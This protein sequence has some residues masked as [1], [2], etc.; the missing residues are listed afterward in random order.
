M[1]SIKTVFFRAGGVLLPSL[2]QTAVDVLKRSG[3]VSVK[4]RTRDEVHT[5]AESLA[6]GLVDESAFCKR[7][8]ELSS[9]SMDQDEVYRSIESSKGSGID[10]LKLLDKIKK[11]FDLFLISDYP[12]EW[13]GRLLNRFGLTACFDDSSIVYCPE[14]EIKNFIPDIFPI[15]SQT[16]G[17]PKGRCLVVD[18]RAYITSEALRY[19]LHAVVWVDTFRL[20]RELLLRGVVRTS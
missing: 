2:Y 17:Q 19:G 7:I 4:S 16:A 20:Q 15:I 3:T 6:V 18:S 11:S 8:Y 14:K 9:E 13:L 10:L 5:L 1:D 12:R